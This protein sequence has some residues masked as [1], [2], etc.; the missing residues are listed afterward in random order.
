MAAQLRCFANPERVPTRKLFAEMDE[1]V[2]SE[3]EALVLYGARSKTRSSN[4]DQK[5]EL[6]KHRQLSDRRMWTQVVSESKRKSKIPIARLSAFSRRAQCGERGHWYRERPKP[7]RVRD[8][9]MPTFVN[10]SRRTDGCQDNSHAVF[11]AVNDDHIFNTARGL[12]SS[13]H[14]SWTRLARTRCVV[15][16]VTESCVRA[17]SS[18]DHASSTTRGIGV[19]PVS[20]ARVALPL[21]I[22]GI[23]EATLI[24]EDIPQTLSV[25][26]LDVLGTVIGLANRCVSLEESVAENRSLSRRSSARFRDKYR[27]VFRLDS[28]VRGNETQR[29][30]HDRFQFNTS[31]QAQPHFHISH[32]WIRCS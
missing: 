13:R 32:S 27:T 18:D 4:R 25:G 10:L 26:T 11:L 17:R 2:L 8:Q 30:N 1:L 28:A 22:G 15:L 5:H 16:T 3:E 23:I 6:R 19:T 12:R 14:G 21:C 9:E 20:R 31:S 29:N 24:D 7:A